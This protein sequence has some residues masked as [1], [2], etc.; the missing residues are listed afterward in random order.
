MMDVKSVT[1]PAGG[2]V[3]FAP[4]AYHLMCMNPGAAMTPGRTVS[5]TLVFSDGS[6]SRADFAVKNAAGK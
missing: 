4:G 5:V 3:S 2:S 1:V 6:K